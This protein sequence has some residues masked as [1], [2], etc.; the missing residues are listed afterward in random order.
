MN[1]DRVHRWL[2]LEIDPV[3]RRAD[4]LVARV[5]QDLPA[6]AGIIRAAAG[7]ASSAQEAKRVSKMLRRSWGLHRLPALFLAV[8]LLLFA[9]WIYWR[10]Y[11][12][13]TLLVAVPPEDAV[14]LQEHLLHDGRVVFQSVE[15]QGSRESVKLLNDGAADVA[16]VQGGVPVP[17]ELPRLVNSSSEVVLYFVRDGV[18]HPRGVKR[19]MTSAQG[20]GSHSVAQAFVSRWNIHPQV[21]YSHEWRLFEGDPAWPIPAD[22]DALFVVKDMAADATLFAAERLAAAGFQL[23]SPELGAHALTLDYLKPREIPPGYLGQAPPLPDQT[24]RT[25]SVATYLVARRD[26]TPR[27]LAAAAHLAEQDASDFTAEGFEPTLSDAGEVLQG[28]EAFLSILIYIGL[29]FLALLGWEIT[30]YRRRFNELNTLVSL[31]SM[32]QSDK[33]VLGLTRDSQRRENLLYL[34]I[35]SDLLGL[36]SVISG[37]YAQENPSLL[38]SNLL[39]I[40][41][42]RCDGLKLNIQ[43]KILHAAVPV[44]VDTNPLHSVESEALAEAAEGDHPDVT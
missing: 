2:R 27:Q 36:I 43:M 28:L 10:F 13:S 42:G 4:E 25:Y 17:Q 20:Q 19:I 33:D 32:H 29:A 1:P 3:I 24:V 5:Q 31:I 11:H 16:F 35:C 7:V 14:Q 22:I 18:D 15:T 38:Y 41:Q 40:I 8:M 6:H 39:E 30:T 44:V 37:Y 9:C 23:V 12:V 34:S 21:S 26:L